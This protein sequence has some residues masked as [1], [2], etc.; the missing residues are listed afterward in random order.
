MF[1]I[2]G[3]VAPAKQRQPRSDG[4]FRRK[5]DD[6]RRGF[7]KRRIKTRAEFFPALMVPARRAS[8][9]ENP[10]EC[11]GSAR[12]STDAFR[13]F[14]GRSLVTATRDASF[15]FLRRCAR[16]GRS[17]GTKQKAVLPIR[18]LFTMRRILRPEEFPA[19]K[20]LQHSCEKYWYNI[21]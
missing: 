12:E 18:E 1:I 20:L 15:F 7:S 2:V 19:Q 11:G 13:K 16:L 8:L 21:Y 10:R 14:W 4:A 9:Y 3:G 17:D 5:H 6:C